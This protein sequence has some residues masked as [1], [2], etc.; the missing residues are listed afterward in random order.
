MQSIHIDKISN[1]TTCWCKNNKPKQRR[2]YVVKWKNKITYIVK[3]IQHEN[4]ITSQ[5]N[6]ALE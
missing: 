5:M 1:V 2:D 4:E 6:V 3:K